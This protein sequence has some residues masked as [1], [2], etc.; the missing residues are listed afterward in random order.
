MII[1]KN[2]E[3]I[4]TDCDPV[5]LPT[6]THPYSPVICG[7]EAIPHDVLSELIRGM[8]FRR[9][10]DGVYIVVGLSR[11]AQDV[12]GLTYEAW[13]NLEE[14]YETER[15]NHAMTTSEMI[16]YRTKIKE[17]EDSTFWKRLKLLFTG[18]R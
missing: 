13:E 18:Y 8:R 9:P 12:L 5:E 10:S 15:R 1:I 11:Q 14:A 16:R 7:D 3:F 6:T 17:M 4:E 2:I